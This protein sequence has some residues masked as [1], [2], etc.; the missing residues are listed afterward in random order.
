MPLLSG[1]YLRWSLRFSARKIL[2]SRAPKSKDRPLPVPRLRWR[3]FLTHAICRMT[4][5]KED[6]WQSATY[7]G[8]RHAQVREAAR[9]PSITRDGGPGSKF[10]HFFLKW[11]KPAPTTASVLL[12]TQATLGDTAQPFHT[13]SSGRKQASSDQGRQHPCH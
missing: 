5:H 3:T 2:A 13:D 9:R 7:E 1:V 12:V 8:A 4:K 6:S 10:L 11:T